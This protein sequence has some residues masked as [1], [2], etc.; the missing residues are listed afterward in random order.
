MIKYGKISLL[1]LLIILSTGCSLKNKLTSPKKPKVDTTLE[2]V[3][4]DSIKYISDITS[5]A[6]EWKPVSDPRA[7]GYNIYRVNTR[8]LDKKLTLIEHVENRFSSHY[9]DG[10]LSPSTEYTYA[11]TVTNKEEQE[12]KATES[13]QVATLPTIEPVA[14]IQALSSQPRQVKVLWRPH[15]NP[16]VSHYVVEKL[17]PNGSRNLGWKPIKKLENRFNIEYIDSELKD[18]T[19][20][21]YRVKAVTFDGAYSK[22]TLG[23]KATTKELP[24]PPTDITAT[25]HIP[26]KIYVK[27]TPSPTKDVIKY[28]IYRSNFENA[29]YSYVNEVTKDVN[30]FTDKFNIDGKKVFYKI[31]ALDADGLETTLN[32]TAAMGQ[33]LPKP[34]MPVITLAQIQNGKVIL[35]WQE[36]DNRA[37]SYI[38][39]KTISKSF[40]DTKTIKFINIRGNRYEDKDIEPN[41]EYSYSIQAV[42]EFNITSKI[43]PEIELELPK[44]VKPEPIEN[45]PPQQS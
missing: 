39:Y 20:Y 7:T 43:T 32:V 19:T 11:I 31:T 4:Q 1:L 23:V 17:I 44:E 16:S 3:K 29:S 36:G 6:L 27:W 15:T 24:I 8:D 28:R 5:I 42:D 40:F 10:K 37:K 33:T 13:I 21:V 38:V 9:V 26:K 22:P 41:I 45:T 2:T 34:K 14:F 35:N 18:N 25:K 30:D 12:S